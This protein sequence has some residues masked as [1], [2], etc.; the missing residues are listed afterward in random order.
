MASH[1]TGIYYHI[2]IMMIVKLLMHKIMHHK[3]IK[4]SQI[5]PK[6]LC[7]NALQFHTPEHCGEICFHPQLPTDVIQARS[8]KQSLSVTKGTEGYATTLYAM[9]VIIR[10]MTAY[11]LY[12]YGS[13]CTAL[14]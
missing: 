9:D 10:Q 7:H 5:K 2:I 11:L 6:R 1:K 13:L 3:Q 8:I 12:T 4:P 14:W